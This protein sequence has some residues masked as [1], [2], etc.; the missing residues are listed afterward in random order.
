MD[1]LE[2]AG[3]AIP[4]DEGPQTPILCLHP[5]ARGMPV[6]AISPS[7]MGACDH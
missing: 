3:P 5:L 4:S 1:L 2:L 6:F 7:A